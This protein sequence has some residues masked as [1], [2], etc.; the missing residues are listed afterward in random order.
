MKNKLKKDYKINYEEISNLSYGSL[1][2]S[3]KLQEKFDDSKE[4]IDYVLNSGIN[5]IDTAYYYGKNQNDIGS[6]ERFLKLLLGEKINSLK[7]ATKGG[8]Y[9]E[10]DMP[11]INNQSNFLIYSC[12]KSLEN[13]GLQ[14]IFLYQLHVYDKSVSKDSILTA[15]EKLKKEDKI[16]HFGVSNIELLDL[17]EFNTKGDVYSTQNRLSPF[18]QKDLKTGLVEYCKDHNILYFAYGIF[19]KSHN[20]ALE[21]CL[22]EL[23]KK[24]NTT[25]EIISL[26]WLKNKGKH[27]IP[28][29]SST[30][31]EN[32]EKSIFAYKNMDLEDVDI[33]TIDDF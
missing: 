32:I 5:I 11:T 24:Y 20:H 2:L 19:N 3:S 9:F 31:K 25:S 12:H 23:A 15:I 18:F 7:I 26:L 29:I 13:M 30:K 21:K 4:I 28:V 8:Y 10:E 6:N 27:I 16:S 1:I 22:S 17:H 14:K 33:K